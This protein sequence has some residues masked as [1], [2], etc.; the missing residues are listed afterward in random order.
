M[1]PPLSPLHPAVSARADPVPPAISSS[2]ARAGARQDDIPEMI[3]EFMRA[4]SAASV[5]ER[6]R[7]GTA[8]AEGLRQSQSRAQNQHMSSGNHGSLTNKDLDFAGCRNLAMFDAVTCCRLLLALP[9]FIEPLQN[10]KKRWHEQHGKTG[11]CDHAAE[12]AD[13]E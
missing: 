3:K 10:G 7:M 1:M 13:A 4:S 5:L 9:P 8:F 2:V 11:R 6:F 12:H